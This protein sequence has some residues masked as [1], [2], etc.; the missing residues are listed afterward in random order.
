MPSWTVISISAYF[1]WAIT[2]I[3]DKYLL[4]NKFNNYIVYTL[5]VTLVGLV[6]LVLVPFGYIALS[7]GFIFI[8]LVSGFFF[9]GALVL[10]FK[11]IQESEA[12]RAIPLIGSLIPVFSL[13]LSYLFLGSQ[14][15]FSEV[16]A[17]F[18]L[19]IGGLLL[20]IREVMPFRI[21][22]NLLWGILAAFLFS[23]SYV[24]AKFVYDDQNLISGFVWIRVGTFIG[25][26]PLVLLPKSRV[27]IADILQKTTKKTKLLFFSNQLL[28]VGAFFLLN[29]AFSLT[30]ISLVNVLQGTQNVFLFIFIFLL[31]K[32]Y[33]NVLKEEFSRGVF[34]QK[35]TA[36]TLI[37]IGVGILSLS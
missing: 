4:S 36:I 25:A 30:N 7:T 18:I 3:V 29:F 1:I 11:T 21:N 12:S 17:F 34:I 9:A 19:L 31:S 35:I 15:N 26:L 16:V 6:S 20:I 28:G 33:P 2:N 23:I 37:A 13:V 10:L 27:T 22:K 24:F 5:L 14:L 8:S 32:I